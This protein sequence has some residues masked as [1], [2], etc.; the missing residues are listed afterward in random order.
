MGSGN[1][2]DFETWSF[3]FES[4]IVQLGWGDMWEEIQAREA[5]ESVKMTERGNGV[6]TLKRLYKPPCA[7][8]LAQRWQ[9]GQGR[10][11]Q[12]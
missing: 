10:S 3:V 1:D 5:T 7:R 11:W 6:K 9:D 8:L 4:L 2:G 12:L